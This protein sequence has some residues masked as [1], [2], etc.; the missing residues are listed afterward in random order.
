MKTEERLNY[1]DC[2]KGIGILLVV[3]THH[4]KDFDSII[5]WALSFHMPLFF[6][7]SGLLYEFNNKKQKFKDVLTSGVKNLM[8][9]FFT[10]STIV[11][12]WWVVYS[13]IFK[14]QP[15]EPL[16]NIIIR[17][18]TTYGFHALWFLPTLFLVSLTSKSYKWNNRCL[19]LVGSIIVGCL[20]SYITDPEKYDFGYWRYVFI[21]IGRFAIALSFVELGRY[22]YKIIKQIN[23]KVLWIVL[24]VS[25]ILSLLLYRENI[26][27]SMA[28]S[29]MGNP[30]IY[31]INAIS[32]SLLVLL[33]SKKISKFRI[34]RM[35]CF[36]G[37]NSLITMALHMD[38]SIE[39][40][41][42]I[43]GI[44]KLST[45]LALRY[46]SMVV[47][48]IELVILVFMILFINRWGTFMIRFPK[49]DRA[50]K[51][52]KEK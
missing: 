11:I 15:E 35:L 22:L 38:I 37:K 52:S 41:W 6:M 39:I 26:L 21:Y 12:L 14:T 19:L 30:I 33:I 25:M 2:A 48:L 46:T 10:F 42:M 31:Y 28:F 3:I 44:T 13:F 50:L 1:I 24:V 17:T 34:G 36:W 18:I 5:W 16:T 43:A 45:I 4:I 51:L 20:F 32:G 40:A 47:I 29:R 7:I 27:V 49:L 8:W 9:P 23:N